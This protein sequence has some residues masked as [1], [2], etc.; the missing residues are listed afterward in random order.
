MSS[1][2]HASLSVEDRPSIEEKNGNPDEN[3]DGQ[4]ENDENGAHHDIHQA[5][6]QG[7]S[8]QPE[9]II[10][11]GS[12]RD[13]VETPAGIAT[14]R[15]RTQT[16]WTASTTRWISASVIEG[17]RG[18]ETRRGQREAATGKSSGR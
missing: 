12:Q 13:G 3:A 11:T 7:R 16:S 4:K 1:S 5:F 9:R 2:P 6:Q 18:K 8:R 15:Y 14:R 17:K 10:R